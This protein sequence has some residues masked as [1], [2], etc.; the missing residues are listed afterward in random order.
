[1]S[2]TPKPSPSQ[3]GSLNTSLEPRTRKIA[4]DWYSNAKSKKNNEISGFEENTANSGFD[5]FKVG[6]S[7]T[8]KQ[9]LYEKQILKDVANQTELVIKS[10]KQLEEQVKRLSEEIKT[11]KSESL[12]HRAHMIRTYDEK[13][14]STERAIQVLKKEAEKADNELRK[15][16]KNRSNAEQ[17]YENA[18]KERD[19]N[20]KKLTEVEISYTASRTLANEVRTKVKGLSREQ[21]ML[22]DE[23]SSWRLKNTNFI[24]EIS[25]LTDKKEALE[26][27]LKDGKTEAQNLNKKVKHSIKRKLT[28]IKN[29]HKCNLASLK[30]EF[31]RKLG[32]YDIKNKEYYIKLKNNLMKALKSRVETNLFN[33][34]Q[35][36]KFLEHQI[37]TLQME[38]GKFATTITSLEQKRKNA[39]EQSVRKRTAFKQQQ[40]TKYYNMEKIYKTKFA[41]Q[42][43]KCNE[44][45]NYKLEL[46]KQLVK[47]GRATDLDINELEKKLRDQKKE[48]EKLKFELAVKKQKLQVGIQNVNMIEEINRLQQLLGIGE[49]TTGAGKPSKKRRLSGGHEI[50]S[51]KRKTLW[52]FLERVINMKWVQ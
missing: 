47:L 31:S 26:I 1:M 21:S 46:E 16:L 30:E 42:L 7:P 28:D 3:S 2:S 23:I 25:A 4:E 48:S 11:M 24:L 50:K 45:E 18:K 14:Q 20:V 35:E 38:N 27:S 5:I 15:S 22:K 49:K 17:D 10:K 6:I 8:L 32:E 12:I 34:R 19:A 39:E 13:I 43:K 37:N 44:I 41:L 33:V 36:I 29:K 52:P 40:A 9:R 51:K